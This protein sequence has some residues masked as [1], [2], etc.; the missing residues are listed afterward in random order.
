MTG[1]EIR[2]K[3]PRRRADAIYDHP[4]SRA[5]QA[6][7][8]ELAASNVLAKRHAREIRD[9][10]AEHEAERKAIL[11]GAAGPAVP[12]HKAIAE[13]ERMRREHEAAHAAMAA[14]HERERIAAKKAARR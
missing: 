2:L 12:A 4:S 6:E 1:P 11:Q 13:T 5:V 7:R 9:L 10:A 8:D 3:P 14:R